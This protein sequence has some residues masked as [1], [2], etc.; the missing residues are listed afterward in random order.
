MFVFI[1]CYERLAAIPLE[2]QSYY[3]STS[4]Y[5]STPMIYSL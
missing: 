2:V 1:L 5:D 3:D 4:N